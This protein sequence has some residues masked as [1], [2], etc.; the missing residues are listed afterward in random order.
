MSARVRDEFWGLVL[1][2]PYMRAQLD[3]IVNR[4]VYATDA[5][6]SWGAVTFADTSPEEALFYWSRKRPRHAQMFFS[7]TEHTSDMLTPMPGSG[8]L[9]RDFMMEKVLATT[10]FKEAFRFKFHSEGHINKLE[11][12]A[13]KAAIKYAVCDQRQ[14]GQRTVLLIDSQVVLHVLQRGRSSSF[15]LNQIMRSLLPHLLGSRMTICP[16]W[17]HTSCNPADDPTRGLE[18]RMAEPR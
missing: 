4:R 12:H 14:W 10:Q 2:H 16:L 11:G 7:P 3:T 8:P 13:A 6:T 17:V 1:L 15:G 5:T 18:V 9:E